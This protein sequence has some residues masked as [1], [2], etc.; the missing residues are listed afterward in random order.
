MK[1][2]MCVNRTNKLL[3]MTTMMMMVIAQSECICTLYDIFMYV[4]PLNWSA[5]SG[6]S[7][8]L[9]FLAYSR[10]VNSNILIYDVLS[11]AN[12]E[13]SLLFK[14]G[15]YLNIYIYACCERGH[16]LFNGSQQIESNQNQLLT[17][18]KSNKSNFDITY[19]H[20][21]N[22]W[23]SEASGYSMVVYVCM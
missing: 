21:L 11:N 17:P 5:P 9:L 7:V 6:K 15:Y 16:T 14:T 18:A 10:C 8:G 12:S 20:I 4:L 22:G 1:V 19:V 2:K 13:M 3:M 23:Q